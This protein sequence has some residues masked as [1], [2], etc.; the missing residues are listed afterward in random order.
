MDPRDGFAQNGRQ[1][2]RI[3]L[4]LQLSHNGKRAIRSKRGQGVD[5]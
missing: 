3:G 1:K 4:P 5:L 2:L